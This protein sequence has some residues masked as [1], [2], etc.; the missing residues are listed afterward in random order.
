MFVCVSVCV[1]G[2][3]AV[4]VRACEGACVFW[5]TIVV[6]LVTGFFPVL[7]CLFVFGCFVLAG[8]WFIAVQALQSIALMGFFLA[9][10]YGLAVNVM[11]NYR[12]FNRVLETIMATSSK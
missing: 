4:C 6:A 3:G 9:G 8:V 12:T 2:A 11:T 10:C 1:C 7:L 5:F